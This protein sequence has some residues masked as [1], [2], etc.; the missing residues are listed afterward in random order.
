MDTFTLD[1]NNSQI[2]VT[3]SGKCQF[4]V[5][6]P[7]KKMLLLLKQDNEG[8]NHWFEEGTDNETD[9]ARAIGAA[10]DNY[11]AKHDSLPMPDQY[12]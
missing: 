3:P 7:G 12:H 2:T 11:M 5:E 8:A 6:I 9:E 10:I 4:K 1:Y